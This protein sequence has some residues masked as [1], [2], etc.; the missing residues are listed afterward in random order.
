MSEEVEQLSGATVKVVGPCKSGK[1]TV[2]AKLKALGYA[3]RA[4]SQEHS[5]VPAMWQR[6]QPCD[7]LIFLDASLGVVRQRAQDES[8]SQA[9]WERQQKRLAHARQHCDLLID[10]DDLEPGEVLNQIV[11]FLDRR[12]G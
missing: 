1:S 2:V 11:A 3:A 5:D 9:L 4:C 8:W 6:I 12:P 7:V 10:T